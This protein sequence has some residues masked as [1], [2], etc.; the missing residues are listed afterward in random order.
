MYLYSQS[1]HTLTRNDS[2]VGGLD[3]DLVTTDAYS[4]SGPGKNNPDMQGV[5]NVG[6]IPQGAYT[7]SEPFD[8]DG[9]PHGPYVLKL[10]PDPA[11]VMFGRSGFLIHGDSKENPG[12]SSEGCIVAPRSI[13]EAIAKSGDTRLLVIA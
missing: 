7:I 2:V 6:P 10:T 13:R 4:G 9:G 1:R 8:L 11:N 5:R 3:A 12:S